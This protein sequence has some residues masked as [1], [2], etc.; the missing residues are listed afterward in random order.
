MKLKRTSPVTFQYQKD[1][2]SHTLVSLKFNYDLTIKCVFN[3]HLL[4][5]IIF[6]YFSRTSLFIRALANPI[7]HGHNDGSAPSFEKLVVAKLHKSQLR[8]NLIDSKL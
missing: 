6:P 4:F 5:N 7:Y 1:T 8:H 2:F 3:Q